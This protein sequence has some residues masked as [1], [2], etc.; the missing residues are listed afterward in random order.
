LI[1]QLVT[2]NCF[3]V[4]M[5]IEEAIFIFFSG[6]ITRVLVKKTLERFCKEYNYDYNISDLFKK[7][8]NKFKSKPVIS[9]TTSARPSSK[10][11]AGG[12]VTGSA[13]AST[14]TNDRGTEELVVGQPL[15]QQLDQG[16]AG[17]QTESQ[18]QQ[19][20][21]QGQAGAQTESQ[22][23]NND[24]NQGQNED[25]PLLLTNIDRLIMAG[26]DP[27]GVSPQ[28]IANV[29]YNYRI[30]VNNVYGER[31]VAFANLNRIANEANS[32]QNEY[33]NTSD[34]DKKIEI[35]NK[36]DDLGKK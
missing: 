8:I 20:V 7:F 25:V 32:L 6:A 28:R 15:V 16:Q 22:P 29:R 19:P 10:G 1:K 21:A 33:N 4:S 11:V 5:S 24:Q 36:Y 12:M 34:P 9:N 35:S 3:I 23:Q 18:P 17:A 27:P 26:I 13:V 2:G 31:H 30:Y 14:S